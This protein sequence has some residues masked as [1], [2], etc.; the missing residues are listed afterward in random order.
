MQD[1]FLSVHIYEEGKI[2]QEFKFC[3]YSFYRGP[4]D[5]MNMMLIFN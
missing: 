5:H 4:M 3:D 2:C 1:I